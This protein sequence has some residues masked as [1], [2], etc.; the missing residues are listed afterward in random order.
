MKK[1]QKSSKSSIETQTIGIDDNKLEGAIGLELRRLR[2][3]FGMTLHVL[4][5]LTGLS[6]AM[7][8]KIENGQAAPSL[9][10]LKAFSRAFDVPISVFFKGYE[11]KRDA[12]FVQSGTGV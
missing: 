6:I 4:A 2:K 9:S 12:S 8:S 3:K 5:R 1:R 10:T 11:D 7:V